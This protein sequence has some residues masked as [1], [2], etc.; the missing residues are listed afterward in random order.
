MF[1]SCNDYQQRAIAHQIP[2]S[3]PWT[4]NLLVSLLEAKRP[5][6]CLELWSAVG[7]W[8]YHI[9]TTI[10]QR[11]GHVTG[12][13]VSYPPYHSS[14]RFLHHHSVWNSTLYH[15]TI[16]TFPFSRI[17]ATTVD[18]VYI[19]AMKASYQDYYKQLLPFLTPS[20]TLVFDDVHQYAEKVWS[21]QSVLETDWRTCR[22]HMTDQG[23]DQV[24]V[25]ER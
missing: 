14:C 21:L 5:K 20:C 8:T 15:C 13:E 2:I 10:A 11:N 17:L 16:D 23:T 4:I 25:A 22:L 1:D 6:Q 19:D 3:S 18:F 24:L 7:R 9:A 12:I